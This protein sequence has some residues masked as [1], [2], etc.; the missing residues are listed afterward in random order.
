MFDRELSLVITAQCAVGR[1]HSSFNKTTVVSVTDRM[2]YEQ[3]INHKMKIEIRH[4][5]QIKLL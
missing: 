2:I 5:P 1:I 4:Q 3:I